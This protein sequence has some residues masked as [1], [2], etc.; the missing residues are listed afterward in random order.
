VSIGQT[1]VSAAAPEDEF[2]QRELWPY[3]AAAALAV[4]AL[5]W[6]I[7]HRGTRIPRREPEP[8]VRRSGLFTRR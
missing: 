7:F 5:E 1:D 2:G 8:G 6:V 3:L 4:L